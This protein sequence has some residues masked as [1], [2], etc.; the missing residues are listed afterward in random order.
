MSWKPQVVE[1]SGR[2]VEAKQ[3][4]L[5]RPR[6]NVSSSRGFNDKFGVGWLPFRT[7]SVSCHEA[8]QSLNPVF[9]GNLHT[10]LSHCRFNPLRN[11]RAQS[12]CAQM[13]PTIVVSISRVGTPGG[14]L[15]THNSRSR[16]SLEDV[17]KASTRTQSRSVPG[18]VPGSRAAPMA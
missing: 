9:N 12:A 14:I 11:L 5:P 18:R 6:P 2:G 13:C 3:G 15:L 16:R 4:L 17:W 1:R 10:A 7:P 8:Q